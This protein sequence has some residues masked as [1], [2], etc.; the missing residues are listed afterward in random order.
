L[1]TSELFVP[2]GC[3]HHQTGLTKTQ[4]EQQTN[5]IPIYTLQEK[6]PHQKQ[7]KKP[8]L[9]RGI[10]QEGGLNRRRSSQTLR[11]THRKK[12]CGL[13]ITICG[14]DDANKNNWVLKTIACYIYT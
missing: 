6:I 8:T 13:M 12:A 3:H 5:K 7:R 11:P 1:E 4:I 2:L 9:Y 10:K 14:Q